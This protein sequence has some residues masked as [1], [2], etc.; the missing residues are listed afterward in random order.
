MS[1]EITK[2]NL[3]AQCLI[4]VLEQ[5]APEGPI[6]EIGCI[7]EFHEEPHDGFSTYYLAKFAA[8]HGREFYSFDIEQNS[9]NAGNHVLKENNLPFQVMN[10]CGK[11]AL[12]GIDDIA[13]LYLD[14]AK[15]PSQTFDQYL[16]ADLIKGAVVYIDDCQP[17]EEFDRGKGTE[18]LNHFDQQGIKYNMLNIPPRFATA[19]AV[20]A[21]G[22]KR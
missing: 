13:F 11:E 6:V 7:R 9:V 10:M 14:G 4:Q 3:K 19:F 5:F 2:D 22:R 16:Q 8:E 12:Q 21:N 18:L 17:I 15:Y 1:I 20:L